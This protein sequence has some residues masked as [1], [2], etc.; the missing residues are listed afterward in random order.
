[1]S[2]NATVMWKDM[3]RKVFYLHSDD[4]I[5]IQGCHVWKRSQGIFD[6][7]RR[8]MQAAIHLY[9]LISNLL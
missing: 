3:D 7:M 9:K 5:R 2:T 4:L 8:T 1:M 6:M